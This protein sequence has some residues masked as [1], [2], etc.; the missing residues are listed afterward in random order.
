MQ[1]MWITHYDT[2]F[3]CVWHFKLKVYTYDYFCIF[4]RI[5]DVP[6]FALLQLQKVLST[7]DWSEERRHHPRGT[8]GHPT[9]M[10]R[11]TKRL[12]VPRGFILSQNQMVLPPSYRTSLEVE[13]MVF[14]RM[15]KTQVSFL[16][17]NFHRATTL[18]NMQ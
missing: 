14:R 11:N 13:K 7:H 4:C 9:N 5:L 2:I 8:W 3:F 16:M 17:G 18:P 1:K 6:S 10:F 15:T 12:V